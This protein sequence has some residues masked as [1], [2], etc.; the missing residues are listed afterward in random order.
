MSCPWG[1]TQSYSLVETPLKRFDFVGLAGNDVP[2]S[3]VI[4]YAWQQS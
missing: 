4:T 2:V 1:F 3:D